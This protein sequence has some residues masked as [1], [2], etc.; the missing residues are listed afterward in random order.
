VI[1]AGCEIISL[2]FLPDK[3]EMGLL[4]GLEMVLFWIS[5]RHFPNQNVIQTVI[6]T[7][8]KCNSTVS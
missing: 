5:S 8:K 2:S 3:N 1:E 7:F 6:I 4:P